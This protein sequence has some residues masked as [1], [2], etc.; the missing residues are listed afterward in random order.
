MGSE[1]SGLGSEES[2]GR[3]QKSEVKKNFTSRLLPLTSHFSIK[4]RLQSFV[5]AFHGLWY[6][7]K[8]EHNAWI[9]LFATFSALILGLIFEI[10]TTEWLFVV[11]AITMVLTAEAFNTAIEYL[12]DYISTK[13][14]PMAG[15][16]KDIA[17]GAVLITAIG[18]LII[19]LIIFLPKV[20]ELLFHY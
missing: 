6:F 3:S 15:L 18:A 17:A 5:Y 11:L 7:L 20:L 12:V 8:T 1:E 9:H 4:S 14:H 10:N 13:R 19:G 2:G 16:I